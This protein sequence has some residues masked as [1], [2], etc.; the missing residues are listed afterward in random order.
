[1]KDLLILLKHFNNKSIDVMLIKGIAVDNKIS[2]FAQS[3]PVVCVIIADIIV[4]TTALPRQSPSTA[5]PPVVLFPLG[6]I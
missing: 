4:V 2:K 3:S 1:M 5:T 6:I